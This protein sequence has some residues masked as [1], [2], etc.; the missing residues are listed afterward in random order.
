MI[1]ERVSFFSKK[2]HGT[3][4]LSV[5]A[6]M[7]VALMALSG[8]VVW[9]GSFSVNSRSYRAH[10][11]FD[12]ASGIHAGTIVRLRGVPVGK[13]VS[14][15]PTAAEVVVTAEFDDDANIIPKD[16]LFEAN[17]SGLISETVIDIKPDPR[18]PL[19]LASASAL[20]APEASTSGS[21]APARRPPLRGSAAAA[22]GVQRAR[23]RTCDP[24]IVLCAGD[25][26]KG[27]SGTSYDD[28]VRVGTR[29]ANHLD[30]AKLFEDL[31]TL[32]ARAAVASDKLDKAVEDVA[33]V[34]RKA[35]VLLD[36]RNVADIR[37]TVASV[38]E[39][40]EWMRGAVGDATGRP[41]HVSP[42]PPPTR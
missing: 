21:G 15:S 10:F 12:D 41:V 26:V 22:L 34:A 9:I 24:A 31:E 32:T 28:F 19:A 27:T 1:W 40:T 4:R 3:K 20:D 16:A 2:A 42:P 35:A 11:L 13:V 33:G 5:Y 38:A 37:R 36:D 8:L 39:L 29:V 23:S 30:R 6:T 18:G 25:R 14:V 7:A 17:Q